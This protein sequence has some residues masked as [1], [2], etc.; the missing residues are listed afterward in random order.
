MCRWEL[1]THGFSKLA[2]EHRCFDT[3]FCPKTK[4]R[5]QQINKWLSRSSTSQF[6]LS[7]VLSGIKTCDKDV[8][9]GCFLTVTQ[10][11]L[12]V[13]DYQLILVLVRTFLASKCLILRYLM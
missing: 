6:N 7:C 12:V 10:Q 11:K 1:P 5:G 3:L 2:D 13:C 8:C 9:R 4:L